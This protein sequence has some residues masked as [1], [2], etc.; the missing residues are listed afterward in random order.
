MSVLRGAWLVFKKDLSIERAT[1]EVVVSTSFF[2]LLV[3]AMTSL[4]FFMDERRGAETAPGV[5][6]IAVAF[7]GVLAIARTWG[8]EREHDALR[9]LLLSPLPRVAI[10]FGKLASTFLFV[11]VVELM[12]VPVVALLFRVDFFPV[13]APLVALLVLGTLGFVAAGTL[14]G[15]MTVRTQARDLMLSVV[16][17]PL[18]APALL[19]AV[20]ATR[21]LLGA[22][23]VDA[24]P[25]AWMRI[26]VAYDV[27]VLAASY[28]TFDGLVSD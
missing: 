18:S 22:G 1:R 6:W 25:F 10:Y 16:L 12:L 11:A 24:D 14:F 23:G 3:A 20:V 9:G 17:F 13:L 4:S 28:I 26:L 2:A 7:A 15:A 19:A 21:E 27:V 5:L 8:R